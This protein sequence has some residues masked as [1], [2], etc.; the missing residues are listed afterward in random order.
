MNI[1]I[2]GAAPS[3]RVA[4]SVLETLAATI[5]MLLNPN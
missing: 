3:N 2:A 5:A 4:V 1:A